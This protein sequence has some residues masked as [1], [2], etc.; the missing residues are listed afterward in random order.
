MEILYK[1][2]TAERTLT[3]IPEVGNGTLR[4]T[5]PVSLN[6]HFEGAFT[7]L[8]ALGDEA[9]TYDQLA[10]AL[11][12]FSSTSPVGVED[13]FR[14]RE[15]FGTLFVRQLILDQISNRFGIISF[16]IDPYD[17][18]MWAHYT[19][20]GSGFVIGYDK[21]ELKVLS[22]DKG[23]LQP[24]VYLDQPPPIYGPIVPVQPESNV[25]KL[26]SA[27]SMHW[28]YEKEWRLIAELKDTIGTGESDKHGP[29]NLVQIPNEAVVRVFYTERTPFD[30]VNLIR[31]RLADKSNGYR[32]KRP[33]KLIRSTSSYGYEEAPDDCQY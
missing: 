31:E 29:I 7:P 2:V 25:T 11:T 3:C 23:C 5:P 9:K 26:L 28:H 1:Y 6:D 16:T 30:D 33:I 18:L 20:D 14:A 21:A 24:V 8:Y 32:A 15:K 10:K 19:S 12:E 13:V 22:G 27:K 17:P 4:A